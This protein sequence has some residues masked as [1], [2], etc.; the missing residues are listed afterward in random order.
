MKAIKTEELVVL[1]KRSQVW[2]ITCILLSMFLSMV[3]VFYM[4]TLAAFGALMFAILSIFWIILKQTTA[5]RL[6]IR[7]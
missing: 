5:I 3:F 4:W 6:E 2:A 7:K 1:L